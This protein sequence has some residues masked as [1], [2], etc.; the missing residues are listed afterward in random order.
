MDER[1]MVTHHYVTNTDADAQDLGF[2]NKNDAGFAPYVTQ[3]ASNLY[4]IDLTTGDKTR[5]TRMAPGQYALYPHFRSDG[6]IYFLVRQPSTQSTEYIGATD[7]ALVAA[8]H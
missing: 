2:A 7:A 1:W 6:W 8:G 5:L 3:G 4:L